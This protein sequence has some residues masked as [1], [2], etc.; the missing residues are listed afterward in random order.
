MT[1]RHLTALS[2]SVIVAAL[3]AS[4][5]ATRPARA[6]AATIDVAVAT[7]WAR[8]G[9][10]R[11]IDAPS[12]GNPVNPVAWNKNLTTAAARAWLDGR[13]VT[14]ALYGESVRV[15]ARRGDWTEVAVADQPTPLDSRGYPGWLPTRQ[16]RLGAALDSRGSYVVVKARTA[17]LRLK[18][19]TITLAYGTR[20]PLV[21]RTEGLAI[22]RTP[23]GE[24]TLAGAARP[25]RPSGAAIVAA[26]RRFVG[27]RYLWGGASAWG[28]DCSGL[29]WNLFHADGMIVPR[30]AD[31]QFRHGIAV[32]TAHL[33][34]GDLLFYGSP[35]HVHHVAI[36]AGAGHMIEA[37]DSAHSVRIVA[38]RRTGLAG[39]RR[40][41][42]R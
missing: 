41:V 5:A 32:S 17:K 18:A 8:P 12:L 4:P 36:Y 7:L 14:Q 42:V 2:I 3:V 20:L 28:F 26:A 13:V 15:L 30:D 34:P 24:G 35:A 27:V 39:A 29:V 21:R 22:V 10:A 16:L 9:V 40:Y 6:S 1:K 19:R 23:D 11:A 31:P 33:R 38:V 25:V 37:P